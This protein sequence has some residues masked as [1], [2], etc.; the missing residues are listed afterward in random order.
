MSD[1]RRKECLHQVYLCTS[2]LKECVHGALRVVT[3]LS[4]QESFIVIIVTK[5]ADHTFHAMKLP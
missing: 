5:S 3:S 4:Q 1:C 2:V